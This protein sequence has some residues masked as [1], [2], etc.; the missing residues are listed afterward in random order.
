MSTTLLRHLLRLPLLLLALGLLWAGPAQASHLLGGE[1]SYRYLDANGPAGTPFR[2]EITVTLYSNGLY[3]SDPNVAAPPVA[4]TVNIYNR[5]GGNL[6]SPNLNFPRTSPAAGS[7][8]PPPVQPP[9]PPGCMVV[10]PNQPFYLLKYTRVVNLPVSFEGYYAV[11]TLSARNTTLRNINNPNSVPLTLFV[12]MAP[13][14]IPNRSPVFSDTA[15]AIVCQNDTTIS[16]NNAFDPDGDRLVYSFG[17]PYGQVNS[18]ATFP[19]LPNPVPY[20]AGYSGANP[21][22]TG[23]GNFATINATTG[24]AKYGA[25]TNG[26]YG[27]AVDV[28]EYRNINGQEVLLG[29]TR[30]D[31][32]LVVST[33]PPT[34]PPALPPSTT[35]PRNYTIEEG[36]SL[37]IP[38]SATQASNHALVMTLNSA[39]LDGGGGFDAT[40]NNNPGTV[41]PGNLTGTAT[42]S[43][44]GTVT[45]TFRL[46]S[47][48]G[49]GRSTP[50]D[51]ALTVKDTGCGG[52][53]VADIFSISITR[54]AGP[55]AI[56]GPTVVCDPANIRT[57]T[58]AGPVPASYI[59]RIN[60]GTITA[61]QGTNSVQ[62]R[63]NSTPSTG[64]LTLKGVST[65]GCPTD[66]VV[67]NVD[68]R[69]LAALS[70]TPT[71]ATLCR[72]ASTTLTV[73]GPAGLVYT[74]TNGTQ[75]FTGSSIMVT[76]TATTTYT[77]TGTDGTCNVSQQVTVTVTQLPG[78]DAGPNRTFCSGQSAQLG[79]A[80]VAGVTYSWSPTT[81]LSSATLSN[82]TVTLTNTTGAPITT[83]YTLTA[84]T[85]N[86]CVSTST[87]Q[88][89]VT[90]G[91]TADAGPAR[92]F[93]S[94]GS[95]QLGVAPVAG[96]TYQWAPTTGL[97]NPL[98]A[99][100]TVSLP[101]LTGA[102]IVV[103]Y[104]LTASTANGCTA[105]STV[106]VTVN[107][108]AVAN[109]GPAVS[110]CS[111]GSA[112]LGVA[113]IPGTTYSWSPAT[114]LSSAIISNP[115]VAGTNTTGAPIVTTYTL[116][117][118]TANGCVATNTVAVTVSPAPTA[119]AGA[120]VSFCS[121]LS[122]QLGVAPIAGTTYSWSPTTGLS[123]PNIANPTVTGTNTTGAPITTTY[124]L[125]ASTANGCT[126]TSTVAVT[127]NPAA[128]ATPGPAV[129]FCSGG[130]AQLGVAAIPGTTYSWSPATGLSSAIISNPTVAGTNTTGAPIVTTYTLTATTANGCVATNTVVVT[131]NPAAVADAGANRTICS[132]LS[133]QL[134]VAA[135]TGTTYSWSP[136]TGLSSA[137]VANPTVTLTN[138]TSAA[139]TTTYT[140]TATTANGCVATS[141][142][143]VTVNP[144][145]VAT[146]GP[147]VS[148]CSGGSAQLGVA[149]IPGT[150]YLWTPATGLS[151][152]TVANP[153]VTGTNTTGAPITTT[154]TL[155]A[156][157]ANGCVA[158]GTV[159]VTINQAAVANA[160]TNRTQCASFSGTIGMTPIAGTTYSWTPTTGLS[161]ATVAN[162]T[163]TLTNT[164]GTNLVTT[165]TLTATTAQ[166]C[167]ATS[168]ITIT[169]FPAAIANPGPAVSFCSG[170]SAQLGVAPVAGTTYLWTPATG[171][172]DA[173]ISNP[174]VAGTNTTGTP[175]VT[176]Y[177]L[178]ATTANG[179]IAT[180]TVVVTVNPAAV[181][182]A[183]ANR[184][185]C[186]GLSAQLGVAAIA[187]TTY[188]WS[189]TTGLSSATV[190]NPTLTL[191]NTTSAA[192][193]TTYTLT[194]TTANGCTATS[195]VTVTV[196]PAAVAVAGPDVSF[197]SGG[198][199][200]L[201]VAAIAGTTYSWTPT[202]GLSSATISNPTVTGTNTTGAPIVTTYTLTAT[203]A[204]GCVATSTVVV[205][206]NPAAVAT[207]GTNR[208]ICSGLSAQLGVAPIAGTTYSWSPATGLSS[209]TVSNPT[210]TLTNTT[211]TPI[212][213]TYTLTATTANGCV[214]TST[215]TV[216][217]NPAAVADAGPAVSF[218]S[219]GSAQLGV[220][221]I[222]GTTY[223]WSPNTGL[224]ST[225]VSNPTVTLTNTSGAPTTATYTL[226]ATTANGC[227]ATSTVTVTVNQASVATAGPNR[228]ICSGLSAQLG[229]A[230]IAGT[231]YSW[232]PA[233]GL[234]SATASDPTV[235]LTNTTGAPITTTYTLTATTAQGCTATSTVTVTVNPAAVAD[236]GPAL[237]ICSGLSAQLGVAPIAGTTYSWSPITG[238]SS[239]T[240]ANP[241]VTLTNTTGTATTTTYTLTATTANG[242]VATSTVVVTVN[243]A[244]VAVAGPNVTICS[245]ATASL[246]GSAIAGTTYSWSPA[247]GLSSATVS[248]P[249]V[250][251]TNTSSTPTTTTYTLT[252][253]TANGCVATSTVVVTVNPAPVVNAG[254]D[255]AICAD[256]RLTLGTPALPGYTYSW[257]PATGLSSATAAQTV[258]TAVNATANPLTLIYTLTAT[259]PQ[260]CV[261]TDDVTLTVNPRPAPEPITGPLSVCPTVTGVAYSVVNPT[262]TTYQW[263]VS[264]GTIVGSSTGTTIAVDWGV[265]GTGSVKLF[266][267]NAQGCSSDTTTLSIRINQLLQTTT[268][269]GPGAAPGAAVCQADGPYTYQVTP[270]A[271]GS[272]YSWQIT[273]GTQV[274]TGVNTV[275]VMWDPVS[276]PA[277]GTII[278]TETSNPASGVR[279]LGTSNALVVNI[280]PSPRPGLAI[281][282]PAQECTNVGP[283]AFTLPGGFATS[284]YAFTMT[285]TAPGSTPVALPSNGSVATLALTPAAGSYVVTARETTAQ[286]CTGPLYTF[287]FTVNPT[288]APIAINGPSFV[289]DVTQPLQY[290]IPN[291]SGST[292]QF[293]WTVTG[294][295]VTAGQG[296]SQV[297]IRF[298][299]GPG[300]YTVTARESSIFGCAGAPASI[301]VLP[302]NPSLNLAIASVSVASNTSIVLT[303]AASGSTNTPNPIIVKRR[304]AGA[305]TPF[306]QVGTT[307]ASS[308]TFT[309]TNNVD[310]ATNSYEYQ[311]E[312][313]NGCG[314]LL[315]SLTSKVIHLRASIDAGSVSGGPNQGTI[316]LNWTAYEGFSVTG[317]SIYRRNDAGQ[318]ELLTTLPAGTLTYNLPN[319]GQGFNQCF[320][321]VANGPGTPALLSNSNEDCVSFENKVNTYTII[322][323][324]RDGLNDVLKIDNIQLYPGNTL[325]IFNRW[326]REVYNVGNYQNN[327]GDG[328]DVAPGVYYYLLKMPNGT[329]TKGWFEVVK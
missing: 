271:N 295:T 276:A 325:T 66:S 176:T 154:Y 26:L 259:T 225:T 31:L 244:A 261:A 77:V 210:V 220:A 246:G 78:A 19:P 186:S 32:Q 106:Q 157:T 174:T 96:T 284:T 279:C 39:L 137:T 2:Y 99:N 61:G 273:G 114:G 311:L 98:I 84:T 18:T 242:C 211:G 286:G 50:Y 1:M 328:S 73:S 208:I 255:A 201:G 27:V 161:S 5:P 235:T 49:N 41:T 183:G 113:A 15:V 238:L 223:S 278:A 16:L 117:A 43:G 128:V 146:P 13:P 142:V 139:T 178:T 115:T 203:T 38:I 319:S 158:T 248:N 63:W 103:N 219:G 109:P 198:S 134:G 124:T 48:C 65:F 221:T 213:T 275:T 21:F 101:N 90:P 54:A 222:A 104:T 131:V 67:T 29:T 7:P 307:P 80:P 215:V 327:W 185:I 120:A 249:T 141:T 231:T 281:T 59:W 58:A 130:S 265:A 111:G 76:P 12:S 121:G 306:V 253:T 68:I 237:A 252:A 135:I 197:C 218:C 245:G 233:T 304:I 305:T 230:P 262:A 138:T 320:R 292:S 260:G 200:Q 216:T 143:T 28:A 195:T 129:S 232:S 189:P 302:D 191:T 85:A 227:V 51:I 236:A 147:A 112:Q 79:I 22:G 196:N 299:A 323:P 268:P 116:T 126:A 97:S 254:P 217:V 296:S 329:S 122:A 301:T 264:G 35:T 288:P 172:S 155:T 72:G 202:A 167:T 33:C 251:L 70:V 316:T 118:T 192:T 60:G 180:N 250:T 207:A 290:S 6:I 297:S 314:R 234:S 136:I 36:Q 308:T 199:A 52:K 274:S 163:L 182:D 324:N 89:T 169:L 64:L 309:D 160:G 173:T 321:I 177:T 105:T 291:A 46:N 14:L 239:A 23:A 170:G 125:T 145:A 326:G 270:H 74:W 44:S 20:F 151:D 107:A 42:A 30:R 88:V 11:F 315:Q 9:I 110:F 119:T 168:S 240:V 69:P 266:R 10:G 40:F 204:N 17:T 226:T 91:A 298:N 258:F 303:L 34:P 184:T 212:V 152:A 188:S 289:C 194:A 190:S 82:P 285:G 175:I 229:V 162:P 71:S 57:Y 165:Y 144:A 83:T 193:T 214:A 243:P 24:I 181:A 94:G 156:T 127:I 209:A 8:L 133:A 282:G 205:T 263:L 300:S 241:T 228:T 267:L 171:L 322:T 56:T 108:A 247:T 100:P 312:L 81:G 95:A 102:P 293:T 313:T 153:T 224:S 187:G 45:G 132:G 87:V 318:P 93:C 62:V 272:T 55:N 166:G 164:S 53:T 3:P 123:N 149:A 4:L 269:T 140:L 179:C 206:V 310:A 75:T 150:T 47:R 287:N 277:T 294:G 317:Y 25:M 256:R 159:A 37:T 148:F 283:V 280:N 257:S 92:N 86:G